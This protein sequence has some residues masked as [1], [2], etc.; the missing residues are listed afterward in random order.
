MNKI[1]AFI[2]KVVGFINEVGLELKK[3]AWPTRSELQE[4]TLVVIMSV[5]V[6]G[7]FVGLSDLVL[8]RILHLIL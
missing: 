8:M 4:S 6:L 3:S 1:Q 2:I 5:I 7:A